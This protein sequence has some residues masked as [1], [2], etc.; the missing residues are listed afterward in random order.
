SNEVSSPVG[1][2]CFLAATAYVVGEKEA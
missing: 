1:K 2:A